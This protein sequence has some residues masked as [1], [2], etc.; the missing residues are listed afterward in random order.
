MFHASETV[1]AVTCK[2]VTFDSQ[3]P[4]VDGFLF[5]HDSVHCIV[6]TIIEMEKKMHICKYLIIQD[7]LSS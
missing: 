2:A 3:P 6:R 5:V 4:T 1:E 7:N